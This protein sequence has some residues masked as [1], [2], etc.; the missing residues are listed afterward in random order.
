M[1]ANH[2]IRSRVGDTCKQV[3]LLHLIIIKKRT[4]RLIDGPRQYLPCAGGAC[5]GSTGVRQL[6]SCRLSGVEYVRVVR[7]FKLALG[8]IWLDQ[9]DLVCGHRICSEI[10]FGFQAESLSYALYGPQR[11][12]DLVKCICSPVPREF[13]TCSLWE[14]G[15]TPCSPEKGR[16]IENNTN[17]WIVLILRKTIKG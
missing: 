5:T 2:T 17:T 13:S 3:T 7:G 11:D 15:S 6:D 9:F 10:R 1:S 4:V 8:T 14:Q 12:W 16:S